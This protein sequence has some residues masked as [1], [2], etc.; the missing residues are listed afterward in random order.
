MSI[1]I[2]TLIGGLAAGIGGT[3]LILKSK[4][5]APPVVVREVVAEKQQD[6]VLQLTDLDLI[7]PICSPEYISTNTDL[8][9]REMFCRQMQRGTDK[10]SD[11]DCES[12]GNI[13][14]KTSIISYC[15]K[16]SPDDRKGCVELFDRRI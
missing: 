2:Y 14:N 1:W 11:L 7:R 16:V 13:S 5:P 9:C 3:V 6:V 15:D 8:L 4:Q 12:I 10:A